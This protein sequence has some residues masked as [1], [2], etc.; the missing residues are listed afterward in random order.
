MPQ[1]K[2]HLVGRSVLSADSSNY[3]EAKQHLMSSK[4][5]TKR[6]AVQSRINLGLNQCFYLMH[7]EK[8]WDETQSTPS[9]A[10]PQLCASFWDL[11]NCS[12]C[13]WHVHL[14]VNTPTTPQLSW[15]EQHR[16]LSRWNL[17]SFLGSISDIW[18]GAVLPG[19]KQGHLTCLKTRAMG[20]EQ[21]LRR[22]LATSSWKARQEMF[23]HGISFSSQAENKGHLRLSLSEQTKQDFPPWMFLQGFQLRKW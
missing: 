1:N 12:E 18:D 21:G 19:C 7:R 2:N 15:E 16:W 22:I 10:S 14:L 9:T 4:A 3:T 13:P 20:K 8:G 17:A 6:G 23:G 5:G 11:W